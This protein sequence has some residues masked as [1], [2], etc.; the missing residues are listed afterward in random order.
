[1]L[2]HSEAIARLLIASVRRIARVLKGTVR[3][4]VAVVS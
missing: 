1:M 2:R 3:L 4:V